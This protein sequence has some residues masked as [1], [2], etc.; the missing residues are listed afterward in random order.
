MNIKLLASHACAVTGLI[1]APLAL[2]A[3]H[4][5]DPT[6]TLIVPFEVGVSDD[7][8]APGVKDVHIV[9]SDMP[10]DGDVSAPIDEVTVACETKQAVFN[11]LP[12]GDYYIVAEGLDATGTV[13][14]DNGLSAATDIGEVLAGTESTASTVSMYPTPAKLY[15]RFGI[16]KDMFQAMCASVVVTDFQVIAAKQ[17]GVAPLLMAKIPCTELP[18]DDNYHHIADPG[19][20]L[21]G[22]TF[23]YIRVQ[24]KDATNNDVGT[25]IKYPLEK[26]AGAGHIVRITFT[27]E[28]D[29]TSCDLQC[30]GG[31]CVPD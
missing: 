22:S 2:S 3:C 27:A 24:P 28:C 12:V 31:A 13:V 19:R 17:G 14:V 20:D 26:P 15:V 4:G 7:C 21:E 25:D 16:N 23:D 10:P 18:A 11:N 5:A 30:K 1:A 9:L 29:A 8:T 6:G